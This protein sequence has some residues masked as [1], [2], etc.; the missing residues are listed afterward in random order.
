MWPE[1]MFKTASHFH[2]AYCKEAY[3]DVPSWKKRTAGKG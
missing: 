2:F 1:M 3:A